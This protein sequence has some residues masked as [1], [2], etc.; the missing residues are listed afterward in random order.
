M[1]TKKKEGTYRLLFD[2][3]LQSLYVLYVTT[4]NIYLQSS[5]KIYLHFKNNLYD[6][7]TSLVHQNVLR[8]ESKKRLLWYSFRAST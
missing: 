7:Q 4:K 2:D 3:Y 8:M 6:R 5:S 1:S